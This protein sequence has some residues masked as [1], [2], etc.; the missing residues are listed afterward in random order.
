MEI[1][2]NLQYGNTRQVGVEAVECVLEPAATCPEAEAET[3]AKE[4]ERQT[5]ERL[6]EWRCYVHP[7]I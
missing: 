3:K 2:V 4:L 6:Q 5:K 1:P 7:E